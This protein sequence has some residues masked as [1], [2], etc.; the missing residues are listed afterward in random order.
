MSEQVK[1][2]Y[3][4][5]F[6]FII[7]GEIW[8]P[9]TLAFGDNLDILK[10]PACPP[11]TAAEQCGSPLPYSPT[12]CGSLSPED[13]SEKTEQL[14]DNQNVYTGCGQVNLDHQAT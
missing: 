8:L 1:F 10:H 2:L 3:S 4:S 11:A 6:A 14:N 9:E 7:K 13:I 5:I 12:P